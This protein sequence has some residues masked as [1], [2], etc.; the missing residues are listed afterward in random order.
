[1]SIKYIAILLVLITMPMCF[2]GF[3]DSL[4]SF[5]KKNRDDIQATFDNFFVVEKGVFYRSQQLSPDSLA[6]YLKRYGI[7]TLINLRGKGPCQC[8]EKEAAVAQR[9]GVASFLLSMSAVYLTSRQ[10]LITILTLFDSVPRPI[11]VHCVGGADRTGEVSALWVLDQ[12]KLPKE[13]ALEQLSIKYGH[14]KYKNTA[15][16]FLIE[17]WQGR[18]W[19]YNLYNPL[20]YPL[21]C[22]PNELLSSH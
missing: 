1:M 2:A 18:D 16:D 3:L 21:Y 7:K 6:Y 14:R 10:D 11:L 5:N 4:A 20:H 13:K 22:H 9:L 19:A 12:M 17:I 15:K 8:W